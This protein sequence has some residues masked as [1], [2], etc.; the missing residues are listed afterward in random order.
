MKKTKKSQLFQEQPDKQY[1]IDVI[2]H[3][4]KYD[5]MMRKYILDVYE[6][7][8]HYLFGY[9]QEFK[10]YI[11]PFYYNAKGHY[12]MNMGTYRGFVNVLRQL[13]NLLDIEYTYKIKYM[14]S[15]YNI[16]YHFGLPEKESADDVEPL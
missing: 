14:Y 5:K 6:F 11:T 2:R 7:K 9:V 1:I 12:P 3:M 8:K 4:T 13:C 15:K 16:V 10:D